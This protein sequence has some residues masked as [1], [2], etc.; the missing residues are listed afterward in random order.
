MIRRASIH[1]AVAFL[2]ALCAACATRSVAQQPRSRG[3]TV[4][5]TWRGATASDV[6]KTVAVPLERELRGIKN[7]S[8]LITR[9][10]RDSCV[11]F[12]Q[13]RPGVSGDDIAY[14]AGAAIRRLQRELPKDARAVVRSYDVRRRPDIVIALILDSKASEADRRKGAQTFGT[15]VMQLPSAVHYEVVGPPEERIEV[16]VD[17]KRAGAYNINADDVARLVRERILAVDEYTTVIVRSTARK[18][19]TEVGDIPVK[20]VGKATIR[21]RDVATIT[22][23]ITPGSLHRVDGEMAAIVNVYLR[24]EASADDVAACL[25]RILA[26]ARPRSIRRVVA[27]SVRTN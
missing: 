27:I 17:P 19:G 8:R 9:C 15:R 7:V 1:L 6:L 18:P 14:Q 26:V 4:L 10:D 5:A 11:I 12:L 21:V 13:I 20:K 16:V 2:I 23:T 24:S 22:R 25:D 3:V